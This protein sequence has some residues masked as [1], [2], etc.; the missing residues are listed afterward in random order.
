MTAV[1]LE[2]S[3]SKCAICGAT[4]CDLRVNGAALCEP[5]FDAWLKKPRNLAV[6][7]VEAMSKFV[8]LEKA[9]R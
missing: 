5:H 4:C 8:E 2:P 1:P 9:A 7:G 3:N 6:A